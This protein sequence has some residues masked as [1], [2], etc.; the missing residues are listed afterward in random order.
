MYFSVIIPVYGCKLCLDELYQR[1]KNTIES[2]TETFEI[3]FVNDASPD[4]AWEVIIEIAKND[5]RVKGLN[6]SRNFGQHNAIT[7]GL[8]YAKGEWVI[9][10]DCDL[11]DQPEEITKLY[12]KAKEG[13]DYVKGYRKQRKDSVFRILISKLFYRFISFINGKK[14]DGNTA[15]FGIYNRQVIKTI[16]LLREKNRWFP[17]LIDWIGFNGTSIEILH[18]SRVSGK[19]SYNFRKLFR[20]AVDVFIL[21]TDHP[22][23]LMVGTGLVL[24][25][26]S[27]IYTLIIIIK[28]SMGYI[29]ILGYSS[30]IVAICFFSGII[31]FFLGIFGLYLSKVVEDIR[32]RPIYII[33][34][35]TFKYE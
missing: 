19:S 20:L 34:D 27:F 10:M 18:S 6:L 9:V 22:L 5:K 33:K 11:Q 32:N 12:N 7:A 13:F 29:T 30:I 3:I 1:I 21:N 4:N 31:I 8:D 16:C 14:I 35:T 23:R 25:L 24:S 26:V 17:T 2:I 28:F 15:N